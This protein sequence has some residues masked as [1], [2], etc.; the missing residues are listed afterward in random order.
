MVREISETPDFPVL[1]TE[2]PHE[3][4][5]LVFS[6]IEQRG[7]SKAGG[8]VTSGKL[9]V[10]CDWEAEPNGTLFFSSMRKGSLPAEVASLEE[11]SLDEWKGAAATNAEA[12][13]ASGG[14]R[15]VRGNGGTFNSELVLVLKT[16]FAA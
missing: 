1:A 8:N 15:D 14:R 10:I 11:T 13:L 7:V 4:S 3:V 16:S 9:L 6:R 12:L 5:V 2:R